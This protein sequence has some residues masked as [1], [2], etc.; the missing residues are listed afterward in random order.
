MD[1]GLWLRRWISGSVK[2]DG[3]ADGRIHCWLIG[4][5][6]VEASQHAEVGSQLDLDQDSNFSLGNPITYRSDK[7]PLAGF[8]IY[9]RGEL[10]KVHSN[11]ASM[12]C[13]FKSK[14]R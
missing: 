2:V 12:A 9:Y 3:A 5:V 8:S 6:A 10:P 4:V 7:G 11:M 13:A 1:S 14:K